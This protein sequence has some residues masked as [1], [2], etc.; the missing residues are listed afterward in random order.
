MHK[1]D[2]WVHEP[3]GRSYHLC[4]NPPK[5]FTNSCYHPCA[6]NMVDDETGEPLQ[7][8]SPSSFPSLPSLLLPP[9]SSLSLSFFSISSAAVDSVI[10]RYSSTLQGAVTSL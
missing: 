2:R 8:V 3:S 1:F 5:S 9:H 6:E 10:T 7:K 4:S